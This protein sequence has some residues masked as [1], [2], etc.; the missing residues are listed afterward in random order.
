MVPKRPGY[1]V[2]GRFFRDNYHQAV[3]RAK[4]LSREFGRAIPVMYLAP[5]D[6]GHVNNAV[7]YEVTLCK[8]GQLAQ[9]D[10]DPE[11][12]HFLEVLAK[13]YE[14]YPKPKDEGYAFADGTVLIP[15]PRD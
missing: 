2:E 7:P 13:A 9:P 12:L 1:Y 5:E 11:D 14:G 6:C 4:W 15:R 3:A 8:A 10:D